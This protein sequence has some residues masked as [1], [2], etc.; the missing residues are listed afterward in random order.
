MKSMK[1]MKDIAF[2]LS[3]VATVLGAIVFVFGM[4]AIF[5]L[6]G[7]QWIMIAILLAVYAVYFEHASCGGGGMDNK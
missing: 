3:V 2:W 6:A 7:T 1:S 5:N 4:E